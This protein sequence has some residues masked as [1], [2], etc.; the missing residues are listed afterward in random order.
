M[1]N[2]TVYGDPVAQGRPRFF[3]RGNHV[4]TYDPAKSRDYKDTVYSVAL[5]HRPSQP[6]T[7]PLNVYIECYR[8]IPASFS[9]KKIGQA[10]EGLIKPTT[11]PDVDNYA[12]GVK[13]ALK[14]VIWQ[15]DSQVVLLQVRKMYSQTPRMEIRIEQAA[16]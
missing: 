4:G 11:K 7:G 5:E 14:G 15:D 10:C 9:K 12:K 2:F 16:I 6:L 3:R 8:K 1:I 13:D